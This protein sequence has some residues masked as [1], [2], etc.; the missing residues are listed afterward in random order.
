MKN[1]TIS[2]DDRL[3]QSSREYAHRQKTSLNTMIRN[4]LET[5]SSNP[6]NSWIAECFALMDRHPVSSKGKTWRR[7]ELYDR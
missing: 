4:Y 1:V 5:V 7:E 6:S 3:L 2:I